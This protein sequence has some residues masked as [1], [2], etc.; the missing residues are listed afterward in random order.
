MN[1]GNERYFTVTDASGKS[2]EYEILITYDSYQTK[3]R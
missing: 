1:N 3:K 2:I